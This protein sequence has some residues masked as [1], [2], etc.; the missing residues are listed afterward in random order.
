MIPADVRIIASKDLFISQS[1][2]T[3]ESEPVEKCNTPGK[4]VDNPLELS[5][6][7]FMGTNVVSGSA[8]CVVLATGDY[9]SFGSMTKSI[10][11]KKVVTSFEKGINSVSWVTY[12]IHDVYAAG[13]ILC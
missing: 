4:I 11:G 6:L 10:T 1:A 5:N 2:L 8:T 12:S 3:G 9:T 13:C 7:A